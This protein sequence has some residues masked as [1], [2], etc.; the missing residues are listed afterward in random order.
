MNTIIFLAA[1]IIIACVVCNRISSK[2]GIPMLLIFIMLG[3]FF[4]LWP[5]SWI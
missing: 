5:G 2:L 4:R 3:S 1:I